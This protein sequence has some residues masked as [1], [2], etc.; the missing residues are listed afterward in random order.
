M[1]KENIFYKIPGIDSSGWKYEDYENF[2]KNDN[3]NINFFTQCRNLVN[4]IKLFKNSWP[5]LKPVETKDAMNYYEVIK[6]PMGN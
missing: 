1:I 3:N 4:K 5:F 6:D 2:I